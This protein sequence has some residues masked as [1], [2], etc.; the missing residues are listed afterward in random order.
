[1]N[2]LILTLGTR[3]DVE[4]Y[5]ALGKGLQAAGHSVTICTSSRFQSFVEEHGLAYGYMDDAVLALIDSDEIRALM[6]GVTNVFGAIRMA[7]KMTSRVGPLQKQM[8]ADTWQAT[9]EA[10]P[11]LIIFHPKTYSATHFA[12]KLGIPSILAPTLPQFA[13]TEDFVAMGFPKLPLGGWYNRFSYNVTTRM[14]V[15]GVGG[16]TNRWR[17]E[18]GLRPQMRGTDFLFKQSGEPITVIHPLSKHVIPIPSDWPANVHAEGY[19]FLDPPVNWQP[20]V[21]LQ[22]F[23]DAGEPPIYVGFGSMVGTD[24]KGLAQT[25]VAAL[26]QA[27]VRG[28]VATGWGGLEADALPDTIFQL[29]QAPHHWLFPQ[30]AAVVHH[31]GAGTTAAGLR[32]GKPTLICPYFGDQPFWGERIHQLGVGPEPVHQKKLTVNGLAEVIRTITSDAAMQQRAAEIGENLRREDGVANAIRRIHEAVGER[33]PA[34][35]V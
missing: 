33:V 19:W 34:G 31:G 20:P 25:V 4:P 27:G 35:Q 3:G 24:P 12:E 23:L 1:M 11:D 8:V 18:H 17:K 22:A 5:V 21:E 6:G 9:A 2:I 7:V 32:A 15:C 10:N 16:Y 29:Q 30:M 14:T 28:I 26:Q 13:A